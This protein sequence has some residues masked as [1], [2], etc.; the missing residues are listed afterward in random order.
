[1]AENSDTV[2]N[3]QSE[4]FALIN[5]IIKLND[6]YQK[7]T[8]NH[9]FYQKA[10]KNAMNNL[11]KINFHLKENNIIL[12]DILNKMNLSEQYYRAI[13]IIN[14]GSSM[15]LSD[16]QSDQDQERII[17]T[18]KKVKSPLLELP[19]ITSAIT[20]SFI[21][22][23]DALKLE[24]IKKSDFILQ[25]FKEL[26]SNLE[27]FPGLEDLLFKIRRINHNFKNNPY[28]IEKGNKFRDQ[29]VDDLYTVFKEFQT[30]LDIH[31]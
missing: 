17:S 10:L 24:G 9:D 12:T 19:A 23:M 5:S 18:Q 14:Q 3:I 1:M 30:Y 28:R 29:I 6:Q 15:K 31:T 2:L 4:L 21:T 22:L 27:K 20:S 26:T 25:L 11:I 13:D 7:G 8:I 16:E